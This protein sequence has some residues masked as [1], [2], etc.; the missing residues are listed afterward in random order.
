VAILAAVGRRSEYAPGTFCWVELGTPDQEAASAF[1]GALLGWEAGDA[2]PGGDGSYT[3]MRLGGADVCGLFALP[4]GRR[5]TGAPPAWLSYVSVTDADAAAARCRQLG[6]TVASPPVEVRDRGRAALLADP[7]GA[8]LGVWQPRRHIGA[9]L[10]NDPGALTLNQLNTPD[11]TA[12]ARFYGG[13]FGWEVAQVAAEPQPY[14]SIRNAARLN[15]G[16][17]ALP[18]ASPAPPHWLVYFTSVD[19]DAAARAIADGGG[20]VVV[21]PTG[22]AATR[23]VVAHDP[24]GAYFALFEGEVDP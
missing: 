14:W 2:S 4:E 8:V 11:P 17:M 7:Q 12:A 20:G 22:I 15:G 6:G 18:P 19:L 16:M 3:T 5:A 13:L 23:I 10:V 1:Y 24:Q 21:P 9:G